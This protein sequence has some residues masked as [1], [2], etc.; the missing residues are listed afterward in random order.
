MRAV[1]SSIKWRSRQADLVGQRCVHLVDSQVCMGAIAKGRSP[2][3][4]LV[5]VLKRINSLLLASS[6]TLLVSYVSTHDNP[7][8]APSRWHHK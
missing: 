3:S 7:A 6:L 1:L 4:D 8:D 5:F 2:S